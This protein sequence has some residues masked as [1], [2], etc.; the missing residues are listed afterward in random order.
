MLW[1]S[2]EIPNRVLAAKMLHQIAKRD[3]LVLPADQREKVRLSAAAARCVLDLM[4]R[5]GTV[6]DVKGGFRMCDTVG[7][8]RSAGATSGVHEF[9]RWK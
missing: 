4:P 1:G 3:L 9:S 2:F 7:G 5:D 6:G 8:G